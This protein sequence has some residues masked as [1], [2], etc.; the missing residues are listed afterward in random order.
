MPDLRGYKVEAHGDRE[1]KGTRE[2]DAPRKLVWEAFTKPEWLKR[3]LLG[4]EGWILTVC[5]VDLRLRGTYRYVWFNE[6]QNLSM[7]MGGSFLEIDKPKRIVSTEKFDQSWYAGEM[8]GTL[9]LIEKDGKTIIHQNFRYDSRETRDGV[10][11]SPME[12]GM[13]ASYQRLDRVLAEAAAEGK[14][15]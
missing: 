14:A 5:D 4:P 15:T 2:F 10:L 8:V 3:W 7:G 6:K 11:R 9:E 12:T 1:I 13:A